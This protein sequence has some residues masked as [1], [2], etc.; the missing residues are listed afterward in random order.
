MTHHWHQTAT[1]QIFQNTTAPFGTRNGRIRVDIYAT[2]RW[3][4]LLLIASC[5]HNLLS[6]MFTKPSSSKGVCHWFSTC[7]LITALSIQH[8]RTVMINPCIPSIGRPLKRCETNA[9]QL[10][11]SCNQRWYTC[12]CHLTTVA[13][14]D[15][16]QLTISCTQRITYLN[17]KDVTSASHFLL[18]CSLLDSIIITWGAP[19]VVL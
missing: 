6:R 12:I 18:T 11:T 14:I 5:V 15:A 4:S 19:F 3:S 16:L 1:N 10:T 7:Q 17:P 2:S 13:K 9:L 8:T